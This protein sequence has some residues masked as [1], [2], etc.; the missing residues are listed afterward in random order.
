MKRFHF[1]Q[2]FLVSD[3][4]YREGRYAELLRVSSD[5][6]RAFLL[7]QAHCLSALIQHSVNESGYETGSM[8][9]SYSKDFKVSPFTETTESNVTMKTGDFARALFIFEHFAVVHVQSTMRN[10]L[11]LQLRGRC[12]PPSLARRVRVLRLSSYAPHKF[13]TTAFILLTFAWV[14]CPLGFIFRK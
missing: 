4:T 10:D 3:K 13:E 2:S 11:F 8:V 9:V 12:D 1:S 6:L 7:R 5:S 14:F